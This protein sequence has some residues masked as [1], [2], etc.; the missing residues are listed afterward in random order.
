MATPFNKWFRLVGTP[1]L[2]LLLYLTVYYID[3]RSF[4][5]DAHYHGDDAWQTYCL[6]IVAALFGA[7]LLSETSFWIIEELNRLIS[8]ENHPAWRALVQ[9]VTL[10]VASIVLIWLLVLGI[11]WLEDPAYQYTETDLL[12]IRQTIVFGSLMALFINAI[13]TGE[14]FFGRWRTTTLEAERLRRESAEAQLQALR[15]QLDPH[16]LFNNLNTLLNVVEETPE[17]AADFVTNLSMVYRAVLQ[18]QEQPLVT[19]AQELRLA[20]SYLY[21]LEKRFGKG[22]HAD[23]DVPDA[24]HDRKLPPLTL[25]LLLE[26]AV[27]HNSFTASKPL[28]IQIESTEPDRL[29]VR[30]NRQPKPANGVHLTDLEPSG[31]GLKNIDNRYRLLGQQ[32]PLVHKTETEF[33]VQLPLL[34]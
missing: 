21:L 24:W 28:H 2:G 15:S 22:F 20:Q 7:F 17:Q 19:L 12:S 10:T 9:L 11:T 3:P 6:D 29:T 18:Q 23:I 33:S 13:H 5:Q 25:Q 30:N 1:L 4:E 16:F 8:W 14:Y 26:N 32:R 27:K 31:I 34:L